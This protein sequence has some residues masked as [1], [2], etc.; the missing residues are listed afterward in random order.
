MFSDAAMHEREAVSVWLHKHSV[1]EHPHRH[2]AAG[3]LS[4][5]NA[6]R[7]THP[8]DVRLRQSTH[9]HLRA[10]FA[11]QSLLLYWLRT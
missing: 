1:S 8:R 9:Q 11:S 2:G 4:L 10:T 7:Q 5:A 3:E 6:Y